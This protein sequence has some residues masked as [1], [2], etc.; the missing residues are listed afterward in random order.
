MNWIICIYHASSFDL[1]VCHNP[2]E[3]INVL[4]QCTI[5]EQILAFRLGGRIRVR[6]RAC[7][8]TIDHPAT[9][10]ELNQES[11][12]ILSNKN[13]SAATSVCRECRA[14]LGEAITPA[15][16]DCSEKKCFQVQAVVVMM[17]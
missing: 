2:E 3:N 4:K 16:P 5:I 12:T 15:A 9:E 11:N 1:C 13:N 6:S 14:L 17:G 10:D 8:R 7:L